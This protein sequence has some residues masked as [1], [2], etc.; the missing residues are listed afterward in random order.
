MTNKIEQMEQKM[1]P[2]Q[3]I[4]NSSVKYQDFHPSQ[5]LGVLQG[6]FLKIKRTRSRIR[7]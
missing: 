4:P 1:F 5:K 7:R 3:K 6:F 2:V